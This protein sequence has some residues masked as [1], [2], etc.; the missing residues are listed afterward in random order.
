MRGRQMSDGEDIENFL[1]DNPN[2]SRLA[3]YISRDIIIAIDKYVDMKARPQDI[4]NAIVNVLA[5]LLME[6][7]ESLRG[8]DRRQR[9]QWVLKTSLDAAM[10]ILEIYQR[11]N[12]KYDEMRTHV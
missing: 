12:E 9:E 11:L 10:R 4:A 7:A 5:S 2:T 3:D 1:R 6:V 8:L